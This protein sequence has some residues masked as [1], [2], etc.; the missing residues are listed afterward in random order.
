M[1]AVVCPAIEAVASGST[2]TSFSLYDDTEPADHGEPLLLPDCFWDLTQLQTIVLADVILTGSSVGGEE[3]ADPLL[4]LPSTV[5]SLSLYRTRLATSTPSST[6]YHL[7]WNDI[8]A[9]K[10]NLKSMTLVN[11]QHLEGT[12]PSSLPSALTTFVL[13]N[14]SGLTGAIPATL[15]SNYSTSATHINIDLSGN[16]LSGSLPSDLFTNLKGSLEKIDLSNNALNGALDG[17]LLSGCN[18]NASDSVTVRLS[19]NQ[20]TGALPATIFGSN[21]W[22]ARTGAYLYLTNNQLSG[23]VPP[24]LFSVDG[25]S[26]MYLTV[27]LSGNTFN[28]GIPNFF[29]Y[30]NTSLQI[31]WYTL[32]LARN[33]LEGTLNATLMWPLASIGA[34]SVDL[35]FSS[36]ALSGTIPLDFLTNKA[37]YGLIALDLSRNQFIG[38]IPTYTISSVPATTLQSLTLS[39]AYNSITGPLS[40]NLIAAGGVSFGTYALDVSGNPLGATIPSDLFA[41][42]TTPSAV[43]RAK[44][45]KIS[46]NDCGF[47]GSLPAL[48]TRVPTMVELHVDNNQLTALPN[49]QTWYNFLLTAFNNFQTTIILSA[50]NNKLSGNL[51]I[52]QVSR[53][54]APTAYLDLNLYDNNLTSINLESSY[55]GLISVNLN[56]GMNTAMTGTLPQ[57]LFNASSN[58]VGLIANYTALTGDFPSLSGITNSQLKSLDLG[59]TAIDFC[60]STLNAP[61]N[62]DLDFCGF[63]NTS[64]SACIDFYP[65]TCQ[66]YYKNAPEPTSPSVVPSETPS[67]EPTF[68]STPSAPSSTPTPTSSPSDAPSSPPTAPAPVSSPST[69]SPSSTPIAAPV[70]ISSASTW[71][72]GLGYCAALTI[73]LALF[74]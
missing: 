56:V 40:Y 33:Q 3:A 72:T 27:D 35:D 59:H 9:S 18:W 25:R 22:G 12:I 26:I 28:G 8:F 58:V 39:F 10:P 7:N 49:S 30:V 20:F 73:A 4:R 11:T 65:V 21:F 31:Q 19:G 6:T 70:P 42:Y 69:S 15:L 64:V 13:A 44:Y 51:T 57:T 2:I 66:F 53:A 68:S 52:P 54:A 37:A 5:S 61:W 48:N 36:N 43:S 14:H 71:S 60:P 38:T 29:D 24:T 63:S 32:S 67:S 74:I 23:T 50:A 1:Q 55:G 17:S 47:T 41:G 16:S 34:V 46:L 45:L 62:A